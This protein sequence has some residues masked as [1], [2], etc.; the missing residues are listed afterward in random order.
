MLTQKTGFPVRS[1]YCLNSTPAEAD[2]N[3]IVHCNTANQEH[4]QKS[5]PLSVFWLLTYQNQQ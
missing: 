5:Q 1:Y 4:L 2:K 3:A